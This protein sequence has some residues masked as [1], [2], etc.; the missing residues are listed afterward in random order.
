MYGDFRFAS[1]EEC[2]LREMVGLLRKENSELKENM[3]RLSS[4]LQGID[5]LRTEN[6][7]IAAALVAKDDALETALDN[8][9]YWSQ[10]RVNVADL[11]K[12]S[13]AAALPTNL[14]ALHEA[15]ALECE[16]LMEIAHKKLDVATAFWLSVEAAAHRARKEHK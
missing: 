2:D 3:R 5:Q 10:G 6:A 15:R 9:H 12:I 8:I 7:A 4:E 11:K 13:E 16:R 14:A 1:Q